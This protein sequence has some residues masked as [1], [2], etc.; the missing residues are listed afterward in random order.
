MIKKKKKNVSF[1]LLHDFFT[2][3]PVLL[4]FSLLESLSLSVNTLSDF[5]ALILFVF[6]FVC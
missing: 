4:F 5:G 3:S 2:E 1:T 6:V